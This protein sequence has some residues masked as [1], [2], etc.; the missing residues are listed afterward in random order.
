[1][2]SKPE[3]KFRHGC[4][5]V[6]QDTLST[7]LFIMHIK[8]ICILAEGSILEANVT[9]EAEIGVI[10]PPAQECQLPSEFR[11]RWPC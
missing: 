9:T 5:M 10:Q 3:L 2:I 6:P 7:F 11:G 4:Q 8:L 1:M